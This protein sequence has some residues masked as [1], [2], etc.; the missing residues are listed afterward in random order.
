ML[1]GPLRLQTCR[2]PVPFLSALPFFVHVALR[3]ERPD[4]DEL[5]ETEPLVNLPLP[6]LVC[7]ILLWLI[8]K[9]TKHRLFTVVRLVLGGYCPGFDCTDTVH[10]H[11]NC[12]HENS[13][14]S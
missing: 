13:R 5:F 3:P 1:L 7:A 12:V 14:S 4:D 9:N 11:A 8:G 6:D 10:V 2:P